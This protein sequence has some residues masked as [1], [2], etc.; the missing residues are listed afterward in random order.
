MGDGSGSSPDG[1][2]AGWVIGEGLIILGRKAG[3]YSW[4]VEMLN[5][6]FEPRRTPKLGGVPDNESGGDTS[7][8]MQG[9]ARPAIRKLDQPIC[10]GE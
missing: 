3:A 9:K 2:K 4:N 6:T 5:R 1:V 7:S 8:A 10:L